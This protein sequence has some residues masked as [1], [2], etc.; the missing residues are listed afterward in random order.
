MR[1]RC[2]L[3]QHSDPLQWQQTLPSSVSSCK[4]HSRSSFQAFSTAPLIFFLP[5]KIHHIVSLTNWQAYSLSYHLQ[6]PWKEPDE[7]H[8]GRDFRL[9]PLY[10]LC[11][12]CS[13]PPPPPDLLHFSTKSLSTYRAL[14]DHPWVLRELYS[15]ITLLGH[16]KPCYTAPINPGMD[17]ISQHTHPFFFLHFTFLPSLFPCR[18]LWH[19][20]AP[21]SAATFLEASLQLGWIKSMVRTSPGCLTAHGDLSSNQD[22]HQDNLHLLQLRN[23]EITFTSRT[24]TMLVKA[25]LAPSLAGG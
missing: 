9:G 23:Q 7:E 6:T 21:S 11:S 24:H 1:W 20:G 25:L 17:L 2:P 4:P 12:S 5:E 3:G 18:Q 14:R 10:P 19:L 8:L 22:T 13:P 16:C 15:T